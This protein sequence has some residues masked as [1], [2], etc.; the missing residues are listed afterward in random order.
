MRKPSMPALDLSK[1]AA[2]WRLR[3]LQRVEVSNCAPLKFKQGS[4]AKHCKDM[5][6]FTTVILKE[7]YRPE[8]LAGCTA[9]QVREREYVSWLTV[10]R[11]AANSGF[12]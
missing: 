3:G 11:A 5:F 1:L 12:E 7:T 9:F 4:L 10:R 2:V 6:R 8:F